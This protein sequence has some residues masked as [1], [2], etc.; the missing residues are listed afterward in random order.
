MNDQHKNNE[1]T[2][3]SSSGIAGKIIGF[4]AIIFSIF[5]FLGSIPQ[6]IGALLNFS[7]ASDHIY[8]AGYIITSAAFVFFGVWLLRYGIRK[9]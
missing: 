2:A 9:F 4:F 5:V 7:Q 6:L 1:T 3:S 8:M